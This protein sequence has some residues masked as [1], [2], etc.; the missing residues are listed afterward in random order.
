MAVTFTDVVSQTWTTLS[1]VRCAG[2]GVPDEVCC[3]RCQV[4][5]SPT[6]H[7]PSLA[8]SR[9]LFDTPVFAAL[10][11]RGVVRSVITSYKDR[12][13]A[14]LAPYLARPFRQVMRRLTAT[15]SLHNALIVCVPHSRSGWVKRGRHPVRDLVTR[16]GYG[17]VLLPASAL[18]LV[19]TPLSLDASRSPQKAKSRRDRINHPPRLVASAVVAGATVVLVD[20]VVTT[21]ITLEWAARAIEAA[22]GRVA[23]CVILAATPPPGLPGSDVTAR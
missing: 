9:A 17:R 14:S 7:T 15:V 4:F 22:G 20:D 1:P 11:Y 10:T 21:G 5:L 18:T 19:T 12:G 13:V 6:I 16:A 8:I 2:C 3:V 23:G